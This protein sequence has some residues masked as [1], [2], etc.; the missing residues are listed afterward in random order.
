MNKWPV[1]QFDEAILDITRGNQKVLQRDYL[2]SGS[3]PIVDQ[4][5]NL[6][7][8][9]TNDSRFLH[10]SKA[11]VIVFGDHTKNIK[12]VDFPFAMGAD[13]VKTLAVRNGWDPK[14]VHYFLRSV[15]LP[16]LGYSRHFKL[17]R[18]LAVPRPPIDEQRRIAGILDSASIGLQRRRTATSELNALSKSIFDTSFPRNSHPAIKLAELGNISTGKTPPGGNPH[19]FGG[20]IP[21]VTPGDLGTGKPA[22]RT[23]NAE[24]ASYCRTVRAGSSLICC[25]GATI[26]KADIAASESAFNQ[27][28]NAI[29]WGDEV[30]DNFGLFAIRNIKEEIARRGA[31]T[32]MPILSKSKFSSLLSKSKFSS[33]EIE[34]P[35]IELQRTFGDTLDRTSRQA[36]KLEAS[37]A[38]FEE[39]LSSLQL[40]AFGGNL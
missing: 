4:G 40:R 25:I 30:D 37:A 20:A 6:I 15:Q 35:P 39:L 23:L 18:Q 36:S 3:I 11:P 14:F 7:G 8:G 21:F 13:G 10:N 32:T 1:A 34:V 26:G 2:P 22:A 38:R 5:R 27:Q 19:L 24:G 31:S 29:E 33:L 28:I 16:T 12:F 9:Y 17:L